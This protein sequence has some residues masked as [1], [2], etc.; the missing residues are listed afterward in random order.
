MGRQGQPGSKHKF[1]YLKLTNIEGG[2]AELLSEIPTWISELRLAKYEPFKTKQDEI[3]ACERGDRT[4]V[5]NRNLRFVVNIARR[6]ISKNVDTWEL[7]ASGTEGLT[8][9]Y[10]TFD[11]SKNVK[12]ITYA[13][14]RIRAKMLDVL[15]ETSAIKLSNRQA[16]LLAA[17][18]EYGNLRIIKEKFPAFYPQTLETLERNLEEVL[19]IKFMSSLDDSFENG[20][21]KASAIEANKVLFSFEEAITGNL[22]VLSNVEAQVISLAFGLNNEK[23]ISDRKIA[24]ELGINRSKVAKIK[25]AAL[26]ELAKQEE[27]KEIF[28]RI[29][30]DTSAITWAFPNNV[31]SDD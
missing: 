9:A 15:Q 3:N 30:D 6:Y 10:D 1:Q 23:A 27:L 31:I 21:S 11:P 29:A 16:K 18:V 26:S 28:E 17:Y 14:Y 25:K 12:F 7:V 24:E 2:W 5:L 8:L 13:V 19:Q 22:S 4:Q 20:E